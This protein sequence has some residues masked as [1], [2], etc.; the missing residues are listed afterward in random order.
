MVEMSKFIQNLMKP[1]VNYDA[2]WCSVTFAIL[3]IY[4]KVFHKEN[5][6]SLLKTFCILAHT[7]RS[8]IPY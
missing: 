6:P 4:V 3:K 5:R 1:K 7:L 8:L 2:F